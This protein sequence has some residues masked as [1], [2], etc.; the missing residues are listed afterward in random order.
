MASE[1]LEKELTL[2]QGRLSY[3]PELRVT[4]ILFAVGQTTFT[5]GGRMAAMDEAQPW[6]VSPRPCRKMR[7]AVCWTKK[8]TYG[9]S[10]SQLIS[11]I[12]GLR[13]FHRT[14][15]NLCRWWDDNW[16]RHV[17][18]MV[19]FLVGE[20]GHL[21]AHAC[22]HLVKKARGAFQTEGGPNKGEQKFSLIW[23]S[24]RTSWIAQ[25]L[26][27]GDVGG[28]ISYDYRGSGGVILKKVRSF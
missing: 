7:V 5:W 13:T 21:V 14:R 10:L 28:L 11:L 9:Q 8:K 2:L 19:R 20:L 17:G 4:A 16:I 3:K 15:T 6:P 26:T 1:T 18:K 12:E 27:P 22:V 25:Q 24:S 23:I